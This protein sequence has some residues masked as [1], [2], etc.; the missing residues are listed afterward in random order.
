MNQLH[1]DIRELTSLI[2]GKFTASS[3]VSGDLI[4]LRALLQLE[5]LRA[6]NLRGDLPETYLSVGV[7]IPIAAPGFNAWLLGAGPSLSADDLPGSTVNI[8]VRQSLAG[9]LRNPA[10]LTIVNESIGLK[11]L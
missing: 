3:A 2:E 1:D 5:V 7:A 4:H 8:A 9:K 6:Q 11:S 10:A